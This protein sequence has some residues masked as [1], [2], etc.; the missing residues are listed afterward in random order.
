MIRAWWIAISCA[1]GLG[2]QTKY[3][4]LFLVAGLI[5]GISATQGPK[6]LSDHLAAC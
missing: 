4:M 3:T 2:L 1:I 5:V 6:V